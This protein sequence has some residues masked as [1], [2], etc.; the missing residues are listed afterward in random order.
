LWLPYALSEYVEK[1]GDEALLYE[2]EPY[3]DSAP[4][5]ERE[6]DRYEELVF[7][8]NGTLYEHAE[9][10]IKLALNR[11]VGIHGLLKIGGG[12]WNDGMNSVGKHGKGESVWLTE[13]CAIIC[14]K[15]SNIA[16]KIKGENDKRFFLE[17]SEKLSLAVKNSFVDGW[18][19]RG[20]YDS[21][22]PLGKAGNRECE[23]DSLSQSFAAFMEFTMNGEVSESTKRALEK[24]F[25]HL[26]DEKTGVMKLLSPPFN[27]GVERPGY[28]KGYLPGIREN[29]GQYTHAAVWMAMALLYSGKINEGI[30]VLKSIN[31]ALMSLEQSFSERYLIEPYAL[32]GDVYSHPECMGRGGWSFYTGSAAWYKKAVL[33]CIFGFT[34]KNGGFYLRPHMNMD[35]D[36]AALTIDTHETSYIIKY[37]FSDKEGIVLDGKIVETASER[38]KEFF[39]EFD[40]NKHH[41]DY[42]IKLRE[43]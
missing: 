34:Q 25:S 4:L 37:L 41:V 36:G 29:G 19:L 21:G 2:K 30:L 7:A 5:N 20:Y 10:A 39:F 13:F 1:T 22:A 9:K 26:Y 35:F 43:D 33:E 40:K 23:I 28:I 16:L 6:K 27:E 42:C 8:G 18:Y 38:M 17:I 24:A 15:F 12:D 32:A 31:P 14:F 3:L 11:G